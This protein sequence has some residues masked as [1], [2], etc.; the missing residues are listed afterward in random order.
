MT[1]GTPTT[2]KDRLFELDAIRGFALFGVLWVNL[3]S[4]R[5]A[6]REFR[7]QQLPTAEFDQMVTFFTQW[8]AIGKAQTLF[9][10]LFGFGFA[11][12]MARA[13]ARGASGTT[14]YLR[15]LTVL[16][17]VGFAHRLL[18]YGGDILHAYAAMGFLLMLTRRWPGWLLVTVGLTLSVAGTA[19][20]RMW[21]AFGTA[22]G[23]Q[24]SWAAAAAAANNA[25]SVHLLHRWELSQSH[26][27]GGYVGELVQGMLIEYSHPMGLVFFSFV[28]GRFM[29]G[30]WI[31]RQAWLQN[32][33]QHARGFRRWAAVLVAS[34]LLVA[35]GDPILRATLSGPE[36]I[37]M[38][39]RNVLD[40]LF[41]GGQLVLALGYGALI[42]VL[43]QQEKW[44]TR[45]SGLGAVG[46]MALTNYLAQSFAYLFVLYGF[47]LGL[48]PYAGAT[49]SLAAAMAFFGLQIAFSRWWMA[50]FRFGPAEWLWRSAMYGTWQ[51]LRLRTAAPNA[52]A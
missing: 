36:Q 51:P 33:A 11:V 17:V 49:F 9:S 24:P 8:V 43:C 32:A 21:D 12:L 41:K 38:A 37:P 14:I 10:L 30:A 25:E 42:V 47:G 40:V 35:L 52:L 46:Q 13:E 15:R 50:R 29:V 5:Y 3:F 34:G 16:L 1:L 28:I 6:I 26:D 2:G 27:Y 20:L 23:Q 48:L 19:V 31:H 45:L 7:A 18:V 44:R 4:H 39:L 22:G